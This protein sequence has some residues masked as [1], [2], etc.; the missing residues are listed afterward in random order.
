MASRKVN[1]RMQEE[2]GTGIKI[3]PVI[4]GAV[5]IPDF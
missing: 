1:G 5:L 4:I 2:K 3:V